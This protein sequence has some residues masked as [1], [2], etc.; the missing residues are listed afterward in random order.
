MRTQL[1]STV[2]TKYGFLLPSI[3]TTS[4]TVLLYFPI[5]TS[6][7]IDDVISRLFTV[8]CMSCQT[9]NV[10]WKYGEREVLLYQNKVI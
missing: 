2:T 6:E 8:V 7:G 9:Y 1:K 4:E 5:I 3:V 10:D